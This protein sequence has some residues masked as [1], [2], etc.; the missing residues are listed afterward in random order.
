M[1]IIYF[2]IFKLITNLPGVNTLD[3]EHN[4]V[5]S[6]YVDCD[7]FI[8]IFDAKY[9]LTNHLS[10][11]LLYPSLF[12]VLVVI[13]STT[14]Y[15]SEYLER[16][17]FYMNLQLEKQRSNIEEEKEKADQLLLN[18]L[19][20][21][22]INN[23][24]HKKAEPEYFNEVTVLFADIVGFTD[25]CS[26]KTP[27]EV[28][29]VLSGLFLKFD[30]LVH[31]HNVEK[32]KTVGDAYIVA[33]G[34]PVPCKDHAEQVCSYALDMLEA[35]KSYNQANNRDL[36]L[37]IGIHTGPCVA[38]LIGVK[39]TKSD[40]YAGLYIDIRE[41]VP[42]ITR[43]L[44]ELTILGFSYD[45]MGEAIGVA[46]HAESNGAPGRIHITEECKEKLPPKFL[47]EEKAEVMDAK[48]KGKYRTY[49]LLSRLEESAPLNTPQ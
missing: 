40:G 20:K 18:I 42:V 7:S 19:P 17:D 9:H 11:Y 4:A 43:L 33:A 23:L 41:I 30:E 28:V 36:K 48:R 27:A 29:F 34:V 26:N 16:R 38:G 15:L 31:K 47:M 2:G 37:R 10:W 32:I 13:L 12:G 8:E 3:P 14:H 49:Y 25:F 22:V 44:L 6:L 45:L 21:S 24:K 39:S 46:A 1:G 5:A 35:V